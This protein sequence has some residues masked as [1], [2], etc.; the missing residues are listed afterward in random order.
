MSAINN[1]LGLAR[2]HDADLEAITLEAASLKQKHER[3]LPVEAEAR[4]RI[5]GVMKDLELEAQRSKFSQVKGLST[6]PW[7][8][9]S[10][11]RYKTLGFREGAIP[12]PV[13][14]MIDITDTNAKMNFTSYSGNDVTMHLPTEARRQYKDVIEALEI[15]SNP[16][17]WWRR[18][19]KLSINY[20]HGGVMPIEIRDKIGGLRGAFENI[21]LL[22][23]TQPEHW[24]VKQQREP[25][26]IDP[27][28]VGYK[29]DCLWVIDVYDPTPT[30]LYV[31]LEFVER[32]MLNP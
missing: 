26:T 31:S 8:V 16:K 21:Y 12:V 22:C 11:R 1:A 3:L 19:Q 20:T 7:E 28:V 30:E 6:I 29:H 4:Q 25:I 5:R 18:S 10:W 27:L 13:F 24:Q 17:L 2:V 32:P 9:L 15:A 23:E 14:A